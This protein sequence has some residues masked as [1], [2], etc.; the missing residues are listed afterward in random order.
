VRP[1]DVEVLPGRADAL[2]RYRREGFVIA[3][4]A[5]HPEIADRTAGREEVEAT[6]ARTAELLGGDVD[7]RYCP[8]GA[9][10]ARCWC[11]KPLP[12]LGVE[13]IARHR[14]DPARSFYVGRDATDRTF[15]TTL[16]FTFLDAGELFAADAAAVLG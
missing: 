10:P 12:G 16:G 5:W 13:L 14:L 11:R 1:D 15:A 9:G 8:H 6:L 4:L 7:L 2:A 3:A